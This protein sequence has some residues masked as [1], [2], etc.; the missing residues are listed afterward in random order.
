MVCV[1]CRY[2]K[3]DTKYV[4]GVLKLIFEI[5]LLQNRPCQLMLASEHEN[6]NFGLI[7]FDNI[8]CSDHIF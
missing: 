7:K 1:R 2:Y 5:L 3:I 8:L 6:H 4:G